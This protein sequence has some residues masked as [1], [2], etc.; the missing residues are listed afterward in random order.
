MK[1]KIQKVDAL[2]ISY[3]DES[4]REHDPK[5]YHSAKEATNTYMY[6]SVMRLHG[7]GYKIGY[8][9]AK[10]NRMKNR[11]MKVFKKYLR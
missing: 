8:S 5:F 2:R 1:I 7:M 3:V 9:G 10:Y 11:V 4:G 6:Y